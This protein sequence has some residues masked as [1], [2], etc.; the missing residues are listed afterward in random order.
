MEKG[1]DMDQE[2]MVVLVEEDKLAGEEVGNR[3]VHLVPLRN[4]QMELIQ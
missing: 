2:V 3:P 4:Y 1:E